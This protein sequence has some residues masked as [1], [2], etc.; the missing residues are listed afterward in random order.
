MAGSR[1]V[2]AWRGGPCWVTLGLS[3]WLVAALARAGTRAEVMAGGTG[4]ATA[5][6]H[7]CWAVRSRALQRR[8]RL[9]R[10]GTRNAVPS[11]LPA[12]A[13]GLLCLQ[14]CW[15]AGVCP[16]YAAV[17]LCSCNLTPQLC[18]LVC[19]LF[20][21]AKLPAYAVHAAWLD[22]TTAGGRLSF[23]CLVVAAYSVICLIS[24][25]GGRETSVQLLCRLMG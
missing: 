11:C 23:Q 3:T 1:R 16:G 21:G 20:A 14:S 8:R 6:F 12:A 4:G 22:I 17:R 7:G 2:Q 18:S 24:Q 15:R 10:R 13:S 9:T 5:K 25:P 19:P